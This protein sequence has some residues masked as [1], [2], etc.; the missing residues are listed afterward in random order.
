[1]TRMILTQNPRFDGCPP[2]YAAAQLGYSLCV[3]A[4][5]RSR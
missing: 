2:A 3:F 1:M 5:R 4:R